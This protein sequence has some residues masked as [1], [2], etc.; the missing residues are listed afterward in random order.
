MVRLVLCFL[1]FLSAS[2]IRAGQIAQNEFT[3]LQ[4]DKQSQELLP[5]YLKHS[6]VEAPANSDENVK[7]EPLAQGITAHLTEVGLLRG[8]AIFA[9]RYLSDSRLTDGNARAVGMVVLCARSSSDSRQ[10]FSPL[11]VGW[12]E[13]DGLVEDLS[14]SPLRQF[15]DFSFFWVRRDYSGSA[16]FTGRTAITATKSDPL[17]HAYRLFDE[18]DPLAE[19]RKQGWTLWHRGNFFDEDTLT[20]HYHLYRDPA[21]TP[22]KDE[23]PHA[24]AEV[25][26]EFRDGKL[27][28]A[29]V[30]F[31]RESE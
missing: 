22:A 2:L 18:S 14:I 29:K 4:L 1:F 10:L 11:I 17:P 12:G 13:D 31:S 5:F 15:G 20:W 24:M 19:L 23:Y 9:I 7:F 21:K 8:N 16:N 26:Y 25:K 3:V 30:A 28:A 6:P 27:R